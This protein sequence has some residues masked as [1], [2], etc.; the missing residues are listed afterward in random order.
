MFVPNVLNSPLSYD[1][2]KKIINH[3]D[4]IL[5]H[6]PYHTRT[7]KSISAVDFIFHP[8]V[9]IPAYD[10]FQ[11]NPD[12]TSLLMVTGLPSPSWQREAPSNILGHQ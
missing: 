10:L 4:I 6:D 7:F 12:M 1:V 5:D 2:D 11:I 9:S 3:I 8:H